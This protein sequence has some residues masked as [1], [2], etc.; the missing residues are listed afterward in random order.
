M[1]AV[2][3]P[4]DG[5]R[6]L[7]IDT[8]KLVRNWLEPMGWCTSFDRLYPDIYHHHNAVSHPS[9]GFAD[10]Y[11][12]NDGVDLV[13]PGGYSGDFFLLE[14]FLSYYDDG[15]FDTNT[16]PGF[17][18]ILLASFAK[19]W[20][21]KHTP[22]T[23]GL[24]EDEYNK[25][26][27]EFFAAEEG[28]IAVW[29]KWLPLIPDDQIFSEED[30]AALDRLKRPLREADLLA[31]LAPSPAPNNPPT[32]PTNVTQTKPEPS[33]SPPVAPQTTGA[34]DEAGEDKPTPAS[35]LTAVRSEIKKLAVLD[36]VEYEMQREEAAKKYG[37]RASVLDSEVEK[38]RD[39]E[40]QNTSQGTPIIFN[41]PLPWPN[42]VN[43]A[44]LLN[45][46]IETLNRFL[47]LPKHGAHTVALW[48]LF[49]YV[50]NVM[51]ICPILIANSPE[52][53]CGKTSLL[54]LILELARMAFPTS[55]IPAAPLFRLIEQY[56][57]T[58]CMDEM[59]TYLKDNP[60][61]GGIINSGHDKKLAFTTRCVG[62]D[63]EVR[64]F[65]TWTPKALA[66]I[67]ESWDKKG[68]L[69]DRSIIIRMPRKKQSE[70][71][72][73]L[74]HFDGS[75]LKRMCI[76]WAGDHVRELE[77]AIPEIPASLN[78]RAA[79]NWEPLLAI[80]DLIGGD[81]P[82]RARKAAIALSGI[83]ERS[84]SLNTE[85]LADI[86]EIL[87][88]HGGEYISTK[89]LIEKLC[90]DDDAPWAS[91]NRGKPIT[92]RQ[93][94]KRLRDFEITVNQ[95]RRIGKLTV[96][97]YKC[98]QF[99]ESFERYLTDTPAVS[100]TQ[101][102]TNSGAGFSDISISHTP[103]NVADEKTLEP[104]TDAGCDLVTDEIP[105]NGQ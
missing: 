40:K 13:R 78:D 39:P 102:Q 33:T 82:E 16:D 10:L 32:T 62:D 34:T 74:R 70:V 19:D 18:P 77:N 47:V 20:I 96:K 45:Q 56:H 4:D 3:I 44:Q 28:K 68:T 35:K 23:Y 66:I 51:K 14:H 84:D 46:I 38:L 97:G 65:S 81:W 15:S 29:G 59:D 42:P 88:E 26:E 63:F 89:E 72:E 69:P 25:I 64:F 90:A 93:L 100:V 75:E 1:N 103:N 6:Q 52:K 22:D 30:L 99:S 67:G 104:N 49:T 48:I 101:S 5:G 50:F 98:N 9:Y 60:E 94:A 7:A 41:E 17:P 12:M 53:R 71:V 55:N 43:G 8:G 61:L 36:I 86:R 57:P 21:Y 76:R 2:A 92:A 91:Y 58:I 31:F 87:K 24:S 105:H 37:M 85:L 11:V 80:A 83:E 79:D 54:K 27:A 95:T 73:R